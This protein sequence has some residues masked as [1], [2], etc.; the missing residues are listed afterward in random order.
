[1]SI[2]IQY[3]NGDNSYTYLSPDYAVNSEALNEKSVNFTS[4]YGIKLIGFRQGDLSSADIN[5]F[6]NGY[7]LFIYE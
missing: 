3:A 4:D 6:P 2:K 5:N 1:M 7:I